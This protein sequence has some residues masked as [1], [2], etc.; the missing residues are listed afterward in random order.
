V[1]SFKIELAQGVY[2]CIDRS[3]P[4]FESPISHRTSHK[5]F[6]FSLGATKRAALITP[7][8]SSHLKCWPFCACHFAFATV[9]AIEE[10]KNVP[11]FRSQSAQSV[12]WHEWTT[13]LPTHSP[14]RKCSIVSFDRCREL[15]PCNAWIWSR[16]SPPH[17]IIR[18]VVVSK[19]RV[20]SCRVFFF[21]FFI[22]YFFRSSDSREVRRTRG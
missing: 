5:T 17:V 2:A 9:F 22:F 3:L 21:L 6:L 7:R 16:N 10:E 18:E 20:F 1:S 11:L 8:W 19:S 13:R 14:L 12:A 15:W 4:S